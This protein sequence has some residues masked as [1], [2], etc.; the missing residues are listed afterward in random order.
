MI[1]VLLLVVPMRQAPVPIELGAALI[2]S[3]LP[4]PWNGENSDEIVRV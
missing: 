2:T 3:N 4:S 1:A